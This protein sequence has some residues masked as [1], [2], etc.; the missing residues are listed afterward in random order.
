MNQFHSTVSRRDFMKGL[1]L[2]GVTLGSASALSPQFR[3]LDELANSA[4]VVNKRGW[5]VKE[6]DYG[7]PTIEIDWNLMKRRDLRGF[8]NWDYASLMMAFP[9]GPPA[10]K[11][12]TP[13]QAAA[14]TAKAKEIWPDYAGP[15]IRDKA[16]SSSFW[17]SAYGHS[18]YC[19][20]QNQHG[21]PTEIPAPR[22]SAINTPV[23]EGTPEENAAMLRA[24]FSL[25]GLGPVIGT[26]M[27]DEKSQNFI[28]EYSGV[29]WT[30]DE[31]V[32]GNKHIV[33]D[34]GITESYVDATSFHIPTSQK[35]V[36]ATHNIS[37]DGFLRR[38][39]AGA[40]FSSTEE[41]SYVRVAYAKSIV[42]QFIRGLGYNV[43]YGHDLQSAVAWDMWSGVGEH[44]RMGQVIGSPEYGG[45]LRTH[46]V[47]YT[48]LPL[49]VTNP[50]DAGFVK[51]CE[52]CGIC[53]E[54]CPVGAIQERGI[55]RSWDN[56]CGQSWA[57]DKQA[58]G[59]KVMYNIPGYKGWRCNLFSCAFTPCASACKSN[60]PFNAIGDGSFVHSIVKS[61]VATSPI[62]NSF[63]TSM[64]G[65]LHYGK[66]DKD[67]ASWW[68][69]PDEWFIYGTHPNLLRQ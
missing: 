49:P 33:L 13:K 54:T 62:F 3:D 29:S 44:C 66:Q 65:V 35:Y 20:S 69:S 32:P 59:S 4:K 31:S 68:N 16:L 18:G 47:F 6:R 50:I 56:N 60:C 43:T 64:E 11:A 2:T 55:D 40:G 5:W 45:L 38:S 17:A 15:T 63:F 52:T 25:V 7:N 42:E 39:M 12:N 19:R 8:S 21:M 53:A 28:W 22:P 41:M 23:W 10:F 24:V 26:T 1:G 57:D 51:F 48:D 46:A 37:C 34:S 27:L 61:T 36:I 58:G 67:P 30:G 14:V 9:G